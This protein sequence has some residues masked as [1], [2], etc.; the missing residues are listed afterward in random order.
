MK[1]LRWI[2]SIKRIEKIR[3]DDIGIRSGLSDVR[4]KMRGARWLEHEHVERKEKESMD[5][6]SQSKGG[7]LKEDEN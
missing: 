6:S 5:T 7:E 2:I 4:E 1:L 3:N